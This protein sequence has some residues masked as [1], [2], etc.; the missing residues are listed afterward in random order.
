M[1]AEIITIIEEGEQ[2]DVTPREADL[3][4]AAG[5]IYKCPECDN[6]GGLAHIA[7]DRT[8]DEA[9]AFLQ[10]VAS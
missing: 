10:G 1:N 4:I 5:L 3:L 9:V 8:M 6:E 7:V 2:L